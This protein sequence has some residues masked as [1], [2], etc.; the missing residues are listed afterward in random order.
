MLISPEKAILFSEEAY[1]EMLAPIDEDGL[2]D[3]DPVL[4]KRVKDITGRIIAQA[5]KRFPHTREWNWKIKV[6]D[7]PDNVNAW[8]MAGGQMAVYTGLI[9]QVQP[10]DE[11]LAHVIGH[12]VA[13]ALANHTAEKMSVAMATELTLLGIAQAAGDGSGLLVGA[14]LAATLAIDMPNSRGAEREADQIGMSLATKAGYNPYA[15]VSLWEKMAEL[16]E[17][18][19]PEWLSTHPSPKNRQK[20]LRA[21]AA[22]MM[23][24]YRAKGDYPTYSFD[25]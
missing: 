6:I 8:S 9:D 18:E 2:L 14:E 25:R 10:T 23:L 13:H 7:E 5:I 3:N 1:V 11:E 20:E 16:N 21:M 22:N 15:A 4:V 17:D 19:L 12:E 24:F